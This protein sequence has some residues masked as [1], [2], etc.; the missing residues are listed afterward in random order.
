[1]IFT[2]STLDRQV[3]ITYV[4]EKTMLEN[5]L[6]NWSVY[7][8]VNNNYCGYITIEPD[9]MTFTDAD[10]NKV[11]LDFEYYITDKSNPFQLAYAIGI[12]LGHL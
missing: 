8:P 7:S 11:F 10:N 9:A 12:L 2:R 1:M 6:Y 4:I 5:Y 3:S